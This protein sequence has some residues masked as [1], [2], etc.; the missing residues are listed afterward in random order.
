[1]LR[2]H[3]HILVFD[4]GDPE[5]VGVD[6]NFLKFGLVFFAIEGKLAISILVAANL[7]VDGILMGEGGSKRH[8]TQQKKTLC[9]C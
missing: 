9:G 6:T 7:H 2:F 5:N 8:E 1:M 4:V 3:A